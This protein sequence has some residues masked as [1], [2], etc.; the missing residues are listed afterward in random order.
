MTLGGPGEDA[1]RESARLFSTVGSVR[2]DS[3]AFQEHSE[4]VVVPVGATALALDSS[5]G[6]TTST[7]HLH[8]VCITEVG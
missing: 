4:E 6:G 1:R 3:G 5:G 2:R 7:W 8:D